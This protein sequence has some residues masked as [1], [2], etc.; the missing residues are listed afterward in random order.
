M[1][2]LSVSIIRKSLVRKVVMG[3]MPAHWLW[4]NI[5]SFISIGAFLYLQFT[6][7]VALCVIP[8]GVFFHVLLFKAYEKDELMFSVYLRHMFIPDYIPASSRAN[9]INLNANDY[10]TKIKEFVR[11]KK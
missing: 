7:Y 1:E 3:N 8:V 4:A 5:I 6:F 9:Y 11:L 10:I 2:E